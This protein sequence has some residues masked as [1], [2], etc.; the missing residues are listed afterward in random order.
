MSIVKEF[1]EFAA[2]GNVIDLAVAVVMGTAFGAITKSLV[3]DNIM[4][5]VGLVLGG[6]DFS[7]LFITLRAAV[8]DT[9]AVTLN[10]GVFINVIINF[11]IVAFAMFLLV[12]GINSLKRKQAE[13]PA[14]DAPAPPPEDVALLREIRDL[15]KKGQ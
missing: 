7:N 10:Y 11:I 1:R 5:V 2:R 9:P 3:D 4:P 14:E 6:A 13:A 15:L 8:G 12:K